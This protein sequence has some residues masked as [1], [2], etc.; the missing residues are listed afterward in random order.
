MPDDVSSSPGGAQVNVEHRGWK[1]RLLLPVLIVIP[2]LFWMLLESA[3]VVRERAIRTVCLSHLTGIQYGCHLYAHDFEGHLPP[4]LGYLFPEHFSDKAARC[5]AAGKATSIYDNPHFSHDNYTPAM[6]GDTHTDYV[7]VSGLRA[8]DPPDYV[9]VF[10]DEWNHDGNR[11]NVI[12]IG[13]DYARAADLCDVKWRDIKDLHE[14]LAR[15]E[16]EL[17]AKG[18]KMKLL[19]PA[20]SSWPDPPAGGHPLAGPRPWHNRR[21]GRAVLVGV[22]V[23]VAVAL[24][25]IVRTV[26]R[27]RNGV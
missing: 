17:A 23:G 15:Q 7:Y 1:R 27:G 25:L 9:L 20:W 13:F 5:P 19:R 14:Q 22:F 18:R 4:T 3:A 16:K 24:A 26:R 21:G 6:F 2:V 8:D 11:V 10:D 12:H